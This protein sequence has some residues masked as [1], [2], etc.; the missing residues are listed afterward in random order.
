LISSLPH[1]KRAAYLTTSI[2]RKDNFSRAGGERR[3]KLTSRGSS[4]YESPKQSKGPA[5]GSAGDSRHESRSLSKKAFLGKESGKKIGKKK[6]GLCCQGRP[7][8]GKG[9]A[10]QRQGT[11]TCKKRLILPKKR[12]ARGGGKKRGPE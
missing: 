4:S 8:G 1:E 10:G 3:E 11:A 12:K 6:L 5:S 2:E 9:M 7:K